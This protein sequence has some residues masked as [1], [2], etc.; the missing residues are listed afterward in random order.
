M[1]SPILGLLYKFFLWLLSL[2]PAIFG[3]AFLIFNDWNEHS[4]TSFWVPFLTFVFGVI[5]GHNGGGAIIEYFDMTPD[6]FLAFS[7]K[8]T[9]GW[10]GIGILV[11]ARKNIPEWMDAFKR[12][13]VG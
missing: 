12:K 7:I 1:E 2:V 9:L 6:S 8:F 4:K 11:Q 10:M 13:L 3:A 5:I